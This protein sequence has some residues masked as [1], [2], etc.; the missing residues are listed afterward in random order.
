MSRRKAGTPAKGKAIDL[1]SWFLTELNELCGDMPK[2]EITDTLNSLTRR[3]PPWAVETVRDFLKGKTTTLEMMAAFHQMFPTLRRAVFVAE[4]PEEA[5][6]L[7]GTG[8]PGSGTPITL[9]PWWPEAIALRCAESGLQTPAQIAEH[10]LRTTG[11][12][13]AEA[14]VARFLSGEDTRDALMTAFMAAF[15]DMPPPLVYADSFQAAVR[16]QQV[17]SAYAKPPP[18]SPNP[19][20]P[21][22]VTETIEDTGEGLIPSVHAMRR[23]GHP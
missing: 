15:P 6:R 2:Q 22:R 20:T 7:K 5:D 13:F 14:E 1:P 18:N 12:R 9:P 4:S 8:S 11:R 16:L 3:Q 21:T 10:L 19:P 23:R 17:S